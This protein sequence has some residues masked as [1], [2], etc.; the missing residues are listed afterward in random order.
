M[1]NRRT[2][3]PPETPEARAAQVQAMFGRIVPRYDLMNRF[4]SAGLDGRWRQA[5]AAA[6]APRGG[7]VLDLGTGTGDLAE[8][9]RRS[10]AREIIAADFSR[11][12]LQA[13]RSKWSRQAPGTLVWLQADALH[14]PFLDNQ[15]DALTSAFLLRNLVD[16]SAGLAEMLRVLRPGGR[17]AALDITQPPPGLSAPLYRFGFRHVVT[18]LAGLLSGDRTAYRY[19]P[20]SLVGFPAA[21][22]IAALL[23]QAGAAEARF[24]Y[25]G[26]GVVALHVARKT[27]P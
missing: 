8:A 27:E 16:L 26:G 14:L 2:P 22:E 25:L 20:N 13:A 19:L 10:G 24:R 12:M 23:R 3:V 1:S 6:A 9:L 18:P 11:P 15:F 5:A 4:M 17:L 21:P 7:R